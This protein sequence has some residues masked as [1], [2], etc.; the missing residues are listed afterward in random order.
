ML[1]SVQLG[2]IASERTGNTLVIV[3]LVL[4]LLLIFIFYLKSLE[5]VCIKKAVSAEIAIKESV[6]ENVNISPAEADGNSSGETRAHSV[7]KAGRR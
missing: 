4:L 6:R 5:I 7:N 1:F 3:V 2:F